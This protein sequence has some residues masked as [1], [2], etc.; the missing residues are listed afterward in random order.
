[1]DDPHLTFDN[2]SMPAPQLQNQSAI[3]LHSLN[4]FKILVSVRKFQFFLS[5]LSIRPVWDP[6][7]NRPVWITPVDH[8]HFVHNSLMDGVIL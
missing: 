4:R 2:P 8:M 1:M 7:Y 3:T 5:Q 6:V